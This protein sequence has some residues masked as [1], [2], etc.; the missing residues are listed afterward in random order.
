MDE[1]ITSV[2]FF[3]RFGANVRT[4]MINLLQRRKMFSYGFIINDIIKYS[5]V[6]IVV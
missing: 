3:P 6:S 4:A 1:E 5:C 2:E